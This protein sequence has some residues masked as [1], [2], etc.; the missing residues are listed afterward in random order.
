M[1]EDAKYTFWLVNGE[2]EIELVARPE[3]DIAIEMA[4]YIDGI[5][6]NEWDGK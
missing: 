4:T 5:R 1:S 6:L 2:D 3:A